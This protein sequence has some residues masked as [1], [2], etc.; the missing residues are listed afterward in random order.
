MKKHFIG[1]MLAVMVIGVFALT[2]S[3]AGS[4]TRN[5]KNSGFTAVSV[6]SG[7]KLEVKQ[8][9]KYAVTVQATARLL[10]VIEVE[11]FGK[12]LEFSLPPFTITNS[13]IEIFI[14][15]PELTG[16]N[17]SG[18]S[19][20]DI[21]M[22]VT[23]KDFDASLSG[24]SQLAGSLESRRM[25]LNLSGG[26]QSHLTGEADALKVDASGGSQIRQESFMVNKASFSLSG[27]STAY[28]SVKET[29]DVDASGGA[30]VFYH[31]NPRLGRT[32]FSGGAGIHSLD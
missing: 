29:I 27:G 21:A 15:M 32:S 24:G 1:F 18:G 31:G 19:I 3:G 11:Q 4:N 10:K 7:M 2:V 13:R 23:D 22:K 26:S 14:T 9:A 30:Q 8:G 12:R 16:L 25:E 17:L 5:Y 20:A 6:A 28:I